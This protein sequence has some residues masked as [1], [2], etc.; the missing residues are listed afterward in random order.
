MWNRA[1]VLILTYKYPRRGFCYHIYYIGARTHNPVLSIVHSAGKTSSN[2][3]PSVGVLGFLNILPR[4]LSPSS[5]GCVRINHGPPETSSGK[6][7][8]PATETFPPAP[9]KCVRNRYCPLDPDRRCSTRVR[10]SR[11]GRSSYP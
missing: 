2:Y 1:N 8:R 11:H 10:G 6:R 5:L 9:L 7:L 3:P 4:Q